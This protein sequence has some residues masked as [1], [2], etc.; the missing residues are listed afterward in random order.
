M[1]S[2]GQQKLLE[3]NHCDFIDEL[4]ESLC[5]TYNDEKGINHI[6]GF[7]LPRQEEVLGIVRDLL[8]LVFP[9]FSGEKNYSLKTIRY[10]IGEILSRVYDNLLDQTFRAF[11]Y[12]CKMTGCDSCDIAGLSERAAR[13][14]LN[15]LPDVRETMKLDVA[16]ALEGDPA[17]KNLDE[18]VMSYPGIKAIT[19][20]RLAH[21]LYHENV[22]LMPRMMTEY[23]HSLTGIDIHPGAHLEKGIFIDHGTGVVIGETAVI[24]NSVKIYQGVTLG[25]LSFP[26]DSCGKIIKGLKRHPTIEDDATIYSGATILGNITIGRG[27]VIGG[28]VWLTETVE[29][30]TFVIT[31]HPDLTLKNKNKGQ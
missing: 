1:N 21:V 13:F 28:N 8:E 12:N 4:V 11:R 10:N 24:G 6:E 26:K 19:I 30:G 2:C 20:Q 14:L 16:A 9:G 27:S 22:P 5:A 18:I 15:S 7:N 29:P 17:A 23:A 31:A 3:L 25:A